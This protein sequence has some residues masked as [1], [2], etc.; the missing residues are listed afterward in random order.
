ML[1][2]SMDIQINT[3]T[4]HYPI[5]FDGRNICV[6]CGGEGTLTFVDKFGRA[7]NQDIHAFDCIKCKKCGRTYS[8]L[9]QN[10]ESNGKMYPSAVERNIKTEFLNL[11]NNKKIQSKGEQKL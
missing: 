8:I 9:W 3:K 11:F 1:N 6:H 7:T 2:I 10:D 5:M 4:T